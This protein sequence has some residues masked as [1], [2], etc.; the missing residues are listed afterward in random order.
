MFEVF[1]C[2]DLTYGG[3]VLYDEYGVVY[4]EEGLL[5]RA[6]FVICVQEI[7]DGDRGVVGGCASEV[8]GV[9]AL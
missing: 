2:G 3:G 6:C 9:G 4:R 5:D 7:S 1:I 8:D